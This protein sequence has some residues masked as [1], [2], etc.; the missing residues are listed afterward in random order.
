MCQNIQ[1]G[2][3][4]FEV[5]AWLNTSSLTQAVYWTD[6]SITP[7]TTDDINTGNYGALTLDSGV[8]IGSSSIGGGETTSL[9]C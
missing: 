3:V 2:F 4:R 5:D 8:Y 6:F 7:K 9:F 1:T